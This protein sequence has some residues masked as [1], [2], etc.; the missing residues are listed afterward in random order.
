MDSA[1]VLS[2][3]MFFSLIIVGLISTL[4]A[5][6]VHGLAAHGV[7]HAYAVKVSHLPPVGTLFAAFLGYNPMGTVLAPVLH[8]LPHATAAY[9]TGHR[10]FPTLVSHPFATGIHEAFYSP[11]AAVCW[12]Q[13]R[14]GCAEAS[15]STPSRPLRSHR[16]SPSRRRASWLAPEGPESRRLTAGSDPSTDAGS[17]A[18]RAG[19]P[20]RRADVSLGPGT[21]RPLVW[22]G[23]ARADRVRLNRLDKHRLRFYDPYCR[24]K[25]HQEVIRMAIIRWEPARELQSVQSEINRLFNTLFE[26][27]TPTGN[28]SSRRWIPA[29]DLV[30]NENDFVLRA[31]LPGVAEKDVKIELQDNVLTISG[32]RKAEHEERKEGYYRLERSAGSFSRSLT[33]PEGIDPSGITASYDRGVLEVHVPK[34]SARKPHKVTINV[35]GAEPT[36]EGDASAPADT[37]AAE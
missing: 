14:R 21:C 28:G 35:G 20:S 24:C 7:P 25:S 23:A 27:P 5:D 34:P 19:C 4:P 11:P 32:E 29:M 30:E 1:S 37:P 8:T 36:I 13:S 12:R 3:G 10:F 9:L 2:I 18:P 15:T 22:S 26:S 31:D 33:L 16:A 17:S 6:T